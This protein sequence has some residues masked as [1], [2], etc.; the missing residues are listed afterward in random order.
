MDY[1]PK[2][3]S[4]INQAGFTLIELIMVIAIL[5]VLSAFAIAKFAD[6]QDEAELS[7]IQY[8]AA[9]FQAAVQN[10]KILFLSQNHTTRTQNITGIANDI[11]DTNNLGYPIG[12][13]KGAGNENINGSGCEDLWRSLLTDPPTV[14]RGNNNADYRAYRHNSARFCS[15]AYRKSGDTANRNQS[16]II[17]RYSA[18]T[19]VVDVCGRSADLPNC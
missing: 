19:G 12:I 11:I 10:V 15:F 4:G 14:E 7:T 6:L 8:T 16:Q 17:I 18:D 2:T 13:S 3:Q 9:N 5:G 1:H